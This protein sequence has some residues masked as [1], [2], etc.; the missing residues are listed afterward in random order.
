MLLLTCWYLSPSTH[1]VT[2]QMAR[3]KMVLPQ[4]VLSNILHKQ[5]YLLSFYY[6]IRQF[7][8]LVGCCWFSRIQFC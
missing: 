3:I 8:M 4:H 5:Q 2:N 7:E 6:V 1:R